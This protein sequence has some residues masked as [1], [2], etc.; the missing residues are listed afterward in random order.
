MKKQSVSI[1]N[2]QT[3]V[4]TNV[5][6]DVYESTAEATK[7]LGDQ[8]VLTVINDSLI[9]DARAAEHRKGQVATSQKRRAIA[10][11]AMDYAL[12]SGFKADQVKV[13]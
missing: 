11:A 7:A 6:V 13:G 12:K 3:G 4:K 10:K 8:G 2:M 9:S 5:S 1:V